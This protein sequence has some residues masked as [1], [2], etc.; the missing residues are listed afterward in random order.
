MEMKINGQ[1]FNDRL[2]AVAECSK[3]LHL[4]GFHCSET[5]L[6]GVWPFIM[7]D[8]PLTDEILKMSM[9]F[10]GGMAASMSSH[11]GGLTVGIMLIGAVFGRKDLDGD[12][13]L[14]PSISRKYWQLF[15][16]EFKTSQC[17]LLRQG[18]P[19]PEAP[20]RCGCIMVRSAVLITSLVDTIEKEKPSIDEIYSWKVDRTDEPCHEKVVPM[21][22]SDE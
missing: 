14:A 4:E 1:A 10:R 20:T 8:T 16:D 13:K 12:G 15:L 2:K 19:G 5:I 3:K 22:A 11:C 7:P 17:T 6:R 18:E 21:K 9:P